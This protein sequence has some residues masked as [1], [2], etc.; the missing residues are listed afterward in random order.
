[1]IKRNS[2]YYTDAPI[3]F[4]PIF[5][6]VHIVN[7]ILVPSSRHMR[8]PLWSKTYTPFHILFMSENKLTLLLSITVG[9]FWA[10]DVRAASYWCALLLPP[11]GIARSK[12]RFLF[13]NVNVVASSN[14]RGNEIITESC[15][16]ASFICQLRLAFNFFIFI[17]VCHRIIRSKYFYEAYM[18]EGG[19]FF[20]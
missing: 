16:R 11:N 7:E 3:P 8:T 13:S 20:F 10:M 4:R 9:P 19:D 12:L 2:L 18:I 1:M 14:W 15:Q 6:L 17:E 5:L